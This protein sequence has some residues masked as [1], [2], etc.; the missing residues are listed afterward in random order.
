[1][2]FTDTLSNDVDSNG[3]SRDGPPSITLTHSVNISEDDDLRIEHITPQSPAA[4]EVPPQASHRRGKSETQNLLNDS[5]RNSFEEE[6]TKAFRYVAAPVLEDEERRARRRKRRGEVM[7]EEDAVENGTPRIMKRTKGEDLKL[8]L[9]NMFI[10]IL[11]LPFFALAGMVIYFDGRAVTDSNQ[12]IF[13]NCTYVV[14]RVHSRKMD[15]GL[16]AVHRQLH[17]FQSFLP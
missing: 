11:S 6:I 17:C 5:Q 7:D 8:F 1:M 10:F 3:V 12:S 15:P 14:S 2:V 16:T 4:Q 9:I 13:K